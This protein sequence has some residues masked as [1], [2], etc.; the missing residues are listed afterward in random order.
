MWTG[1]KCHAHAQSCESSVVHC[2]SFLLC[3]VCDH[4][5]SPNGN[6]QRRLSSCSPQCPS[7]PLPGDYCYYIIIIIDLILRE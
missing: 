4:Y 7:Y 6:R 5:Y 2:L 3:T 1:G